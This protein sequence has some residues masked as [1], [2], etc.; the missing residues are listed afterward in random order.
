MALVLAA[1]M[2]TN[3]AVL[4]APAERPRR[5]PPMPR[6]RRNALRCSALLDRDL[7]RNGVRDRPV[8][9]HREMVGA[10]EAGRGAIGD[11]KPI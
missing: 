11:G 3:S 9:V 4:S 6:E 7:D 1:L 5:T 10:D 8:G 2:R